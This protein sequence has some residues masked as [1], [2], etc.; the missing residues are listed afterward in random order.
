MDDEVQ[1]VVRMS[2]AMRQ[3]A[4]ARYGSRG[5]APRLRELLAADLA[6]EAPGEPEP[7]AANPVSAMRAP[8]RGC[9]IKGCRSRS[10]PAREPGKLRC[11]DHPAQTWDA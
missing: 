7:M 2:L 3:A 4:K 8:Q 11:F 10:I 1:V 5:V 9:R 6:S